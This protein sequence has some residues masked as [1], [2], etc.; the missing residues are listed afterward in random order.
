MKNSEFRGKLRNSECVRT[1][2]VTLTNSKLPIISICV[3]CKYNFRHL[4]YFSHQVQVS[5]YLGYMFRQIGPTQNEMLKT[6]KTQPM[7]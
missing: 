6:G 4:V 1:L 2:Q 5:E 7:C 3:N